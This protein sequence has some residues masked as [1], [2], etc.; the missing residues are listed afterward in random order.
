M[1]IKAILLALSFCVLSLS[2][3]RAESKDM[4]LN[5]RSGEKI[6]FPISSH[7]NMSFD[8]GQVRLVSPQLTVEYAISDVESITFTPST[9]GLDELH[10]SQGEIANAGGQILF[11]GFE[12]GTLIRVFDLDGKVCAE[13]AIDASGQLAMPMQQFAPGAYVI[14]ANSKSYKF[15]KS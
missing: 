2:A 14:Q 7:P 3:L 10:L 12:P 15:L 9:S 1:K 4:N 8:Q 13:A 11:S 6:V 5:L